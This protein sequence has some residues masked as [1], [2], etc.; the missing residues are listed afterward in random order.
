MA[1]DTYEDPEAYEDGVYYPVSDD[2]GE[3]G[4]QNLI[5]FTLLLLLRDYF[6][7][8]GR[9]VLV[10]SDQFF[11]YRR[12]DPGAVVSP[13]V[14][15]IDD[16]TT[17]QQDI[18]SWKVWQRGKVPDLALEIV[19]DEYRKDYADVLLER[20]EA[21]GVRELVRYD[22]EHA[23]HKHRQLLSHWVRDGH[24]LVPRPTLHD[25]IRCVSFDLWLV[26][27]PD[28][29]MRLGLGPHGATL[30]PTPAERARHEAERARHEADRARQAEAEVQRLRDELTRLR[31]G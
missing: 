8:Q 7:A 26:L 22:P 30:W 31:G 12:G 3:S 27:H 4:L 14:Y 19:S 23:G 18:K 28:R 15:L 10:G 29:T 9:A 17:E 6:A 21:L 20:Y 11:Y 2:M 16:E 5:N 13:D 1:L 24:R 25:R